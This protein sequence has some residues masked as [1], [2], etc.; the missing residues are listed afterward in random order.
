MGGDDAP[1]AVVAGAVAAL[2]E[3]AALSLALVGDADALGTALDEAACDTATDRLAVVHAR[4]H[5][6]MC[7]DAVAAL[8]AKPDTSIARA[9]G[10]VALGD[11]DAVVSAGNTGGVVAAASFALPRLPGARRAGIAAPFPTAGGSCL[12]VDVGAALT[13]RPDD[14]VGYAVMA[15]EFARHVIGVESPRV[16][17]LSVGEEQGKGGPTVRAAFD[18]LAAA[19]G[20]DFVGNLEGRDLSSGRAD[21][22]VCDG[23]VGNVVLKSAEGLL[24]TFVHDPLGRLER[25]S[26]ATLPGARSALEALRE[27]RERTDYTRYGGAPLLG[28]EAV[29]VIGHGRSPAPAIANAI[30]GAAE[31][32]RH[33]VG[34]HIKAALARQCAA[35]APPEPTT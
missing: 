17:L 33:E 26:D 1:R 19:P 16:G 22:A 23:F 24:E 34:R 20:I 3:D 14:L 6:E 32:V 21:V 5:V 35:A 9:V 4:E 28:H 31:Q 13:A 29:V 15:S 10:L 7:E 30:A 25:S 18:A 12:L 11:C 2:S 8:R 27:L